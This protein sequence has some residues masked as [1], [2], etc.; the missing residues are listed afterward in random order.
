MK[1]GSGRDKKLFKKYRMNF[2]S[3]ATSSGSLWILE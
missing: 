3:G 2:K 1:S